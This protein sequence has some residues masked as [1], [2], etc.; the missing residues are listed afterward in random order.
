MPVDDQERD[1]RIERLE[2]LLDQVEALPDPHARATAE[3]TLRA[4][5]ELYGE[6]LARILAHV[7][8]QGGEEAV[9]ALAADELVAYLL[10]LHG[11]HPE[12][13]EERVARALESVRP[14]LRS[15][16]G[17]VELLGIEDGVARLRLQGS[18]SGC[19]SS[20]MTLDRAI[21]EAI[22]QAAPDLAGIEAEGVAAPAPQPAP[23]TFTPRRP[24]QQRN[25]VSE[26]GG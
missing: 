3:E 8:D 26:K 15:H 19:P 21:E 18:C 13:V 22:A 12:R 16:G 9:R 17:D 2:T 24:R 20:A 7:A 1:A 5:L 10:L 25:A 6:G 11:L 4:L 23:V 14:Y